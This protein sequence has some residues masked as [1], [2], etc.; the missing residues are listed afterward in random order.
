[1]EKARFVFARGE[2]YE[3]VVE[4]LNDSFYLWLSDAY[5][6]VTVYGDPAINQVEQA[7][8]EAGIK[9]KTIR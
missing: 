8:D 5:G 6:R 7:L 9:Y 4:A 2:D 1:M 3:R